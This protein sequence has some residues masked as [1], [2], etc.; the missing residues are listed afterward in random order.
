MVVSFLD[1]GQGTCT[2]AQLP[3]GGDC[4]TEQFDP[5]PKPDRPLSLATADLAA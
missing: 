5:R 3:D 1:V 2:L 4:Q